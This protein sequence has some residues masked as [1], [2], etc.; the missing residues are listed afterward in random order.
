MVTDNVIGPIP[1]VLLLLFS[2]VTTILADTPTMTLPKLRLVG[3][4]LMGADTVSVKLWI[5]G[6]PTPF[7]AINQKVNTPL[8]VGVPLSVNS[9]TAS[10]SRFAWSISRA[11]SAWTEVAGR[12][13]FGTV[14][15]P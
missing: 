7:D 2:R 11:F 4:T 10:V 9:G 5:A 6:E 3:V 12:E 8:T 1:T 13:V 15:K 14:R